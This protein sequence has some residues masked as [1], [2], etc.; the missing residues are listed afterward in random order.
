MQSP[1]FFSWVWLNKIDFVSS[2]VQAAEYPSGI[3]LGDIPLPEGE[4][5]APAVVCALFCGLG[6]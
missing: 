5:P 2:R 3:V 4:A 6:V 1:V